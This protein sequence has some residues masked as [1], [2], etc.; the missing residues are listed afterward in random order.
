LS[1]LFN[2]RPKTARIAQLEAGGEA[3]QRFARLL[4]GLAGEVTVQLQRLLLAALLQEPAD[5]LELVIQ[6]RR[7]FR[8][9]PEA[10]V[11]V[12]VSHVVLQ[13][14]DAPVQRV[15]AGVCVIFHAATLPR[16]P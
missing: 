2:A 13:L 5:R 1:N 12:Q 8:E 3:L 7:A 11:L 15:D 9:R 10:N 4:L 16:V 6:R 14:L